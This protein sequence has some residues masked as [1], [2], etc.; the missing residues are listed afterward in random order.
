[1]LP[2]LKIKLCTFLYFILFLFE[3]VMFCVCE[4]QQNLY[5]CNYFKMYV[6]VHII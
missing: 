1:M 3:N 4:I 6:Y 2:I 5:V